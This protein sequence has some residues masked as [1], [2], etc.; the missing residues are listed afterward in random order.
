MDSW[1]LARGR[2]KLGRAALE[3]GLDPAEEREARDDQEAASAARDLGRASIHPPPNQ[4]PPAGRNAL[5][6]LASVGAA[7]N[8]P[9][10]AGWPKP[11]PHALAS[12]ASGAVARRF[13]KGGA[14]PGALA[15]FDD[16]A[17]EAWKSWAGSDSAEERALGRLGGRIDKRTSN[18]TSFLI[19]PPA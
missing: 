17:A 18:W 10:V 16:A 6:A 2:L 4:A 15:A 19:P 9:P 12:V 1:E 14:V 8:A 13:G 11:P 7:A 5:A 3:R